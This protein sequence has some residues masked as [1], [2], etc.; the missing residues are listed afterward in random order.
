MATRE[1]WLRH[2]DVDVPGA[3]GTR[4]ASHAVQPWRR[5]PHRGRIAALAVEVRRPGGLLAG[6]T[7]TPT[8]WLAMGAI[9]GAVVL[10]TRET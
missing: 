10:L 1:K 4:D 9:L 2:L 8:A 3:P 6:E 7:M 5:H